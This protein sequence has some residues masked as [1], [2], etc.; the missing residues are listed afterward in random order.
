M[1]LLDADYPARLRDIRESPPF[2]FYKGEIQH[3]DVGMPIV[4]SR[5]AS[6]NGPRRASET[7]ELLVEQKT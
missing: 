5:H 6:T 2:I 7:A 3:Y 4:S 1:K